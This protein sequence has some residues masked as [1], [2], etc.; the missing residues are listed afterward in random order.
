MAIAQPDLAI[1]VQT[2]GETAVLRLSGEL[3]AESASLLVAHGERAALSGVRYLVLDCRLL[4]FCDSCGVRAMLTLADRVQPDGSVTIAC[5]SDLLR[6]TLEII[7]V[8]DRFALA[9]EPA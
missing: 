3:D 6:R 7:G 4:A 5:P 9:D 1:A 8:T 2:A